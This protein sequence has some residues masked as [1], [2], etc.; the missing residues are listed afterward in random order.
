[1]FKVNK[2]KELPPSLSFKQPSKPSQSILNKLYKYSF[3]STGKGVYIVKDAI[4][5]DGRYN[6]SF[7]GYD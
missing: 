7:F 2:I 1:M 5:K 4:I 3:S 6:N